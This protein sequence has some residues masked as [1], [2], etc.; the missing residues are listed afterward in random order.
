[1]PVRA[2]LA[3]WALFEADP[4]LAAKAREQLALLAGWCRSR[5]EAR[6]GPVVLRGPVSDERG[7]GARDGARR[8]ELPGPV[9]RA[10]V[11]RAGRR[12]GRGRTGRRMGD[13]ARLV[14]APQAVPPELRERRRQAPGP[15][16][17]A[18]RRHDR[19]RGR[20]DDPVDDGARRPSGRRGRRAPLRLR[21]ARPRRAL[22][23]LLHRAQPLGARPLLDRPARGRR[24]ALARGL[25]QP[26]HPRPDR[27]LRGLPRQRLPD[28]AGPDRAGERG[29]AAGGLSRGGAHPLARRAGV[30]TR[31]RPRWS[32]RCSATSSTSPSGTTRRCEAGSTRSGS[33]RPRSKDSASPRRGGS[34]P[35]SRTRAS[36]R[37]SEPPGGA[38]LLRDFRERLEREYNE[39]LALRGAVARYAAWRASNPRATAAARRQL[40]A[41]MARLYGL[42]AHGELARYHLYRRTYFDDA[43]PAVT[44]AL[45][46]VLQ[47]LFERPGEPAT[48]LVELSELQS[49]LVSRE[50]RRAFG[51]LV[52]PRVEPLQDAELLNP[53]GGA[54]V[55]LV[56]HVVDSRVGHFTVR[57][58]SGPAEVGRLYRLLADSGL[59]PVPASR[60]LVLLDREERVVGGITWRTAS[61]RVAHVEGAR[62]RSGAALAASRGRARRG[63]QR[64]ARERGL[65]RDP[66]ALRTGPVPVRPRLP[67]GPS[68]G[69]PRALPRA[70]ADGGD[71][72]V[73]GPPA[74]ESRLPHLL[75]ASR[76]AGRRESAP[77]ILEHPL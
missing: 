2:E 13:A 19:R 48:R 18:A 55:V 37:P 45:D 58:P 40:V 17:R 56:T 44:D 1:M 8:P 42:E 26:V 47:R 70:P 35:S 15:A 54:G 67:R 65:R 21:A 72:R 23:R 64:P 39:P 76:T 31:G 50:D 30:R 27:L 36:P 38:A 69:R 51:E 46:R 59:A 7:A 25:A 11:R 63:L 22:D 24:D 73:S 32:S 61:P 62:R 20:G 28:P 53:P 6:G 52:F 68:L 49:A 16:A 14:A 66:H 10:G 9:R 4:P 3:T 43:A 57:E 33:T 5:F 60:H 12:A 71:A 75:R 29:R 41:H 74:T 34:W 77:R